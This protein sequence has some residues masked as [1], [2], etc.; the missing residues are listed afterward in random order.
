MEICNLISS[1]NVFIF[2]A[3]ISLVEEFIYAFATLS[4][5]STTVTEVTHIIMNIY[6]GLGATAL[7]TLT[8]D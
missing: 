6:M 3:Y 5:I 1:V 2:N 7:Y 8:R 4:V